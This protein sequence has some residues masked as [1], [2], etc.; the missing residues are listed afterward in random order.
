MEWM[1]WN[2][3]HGNGTQC[4]LSDFPTVFAR[5]QQE[6]KA[7]RSKIAEDLYCGTRQDPIFGLIIFQNVF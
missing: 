4:V 7:P 2:V 1:E 3:L 6:F 5:S